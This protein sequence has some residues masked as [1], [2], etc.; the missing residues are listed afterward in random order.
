M[1]I[2]EKIFSPPKIPYLPF[3]KAQKKRN[4]QIYVWDASKWCRFSQLPAVKQ[5]PFMVHGKQI[6]GPC[7]G[8]KIIGQKNSKIHQ[9]NSSKKNHQKL[10]HRYTYLKKA[11]EST[12][13]TILGILGKLDV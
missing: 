13:K 3:T 5:V 12:R 1:L 2:I 6:F 9:K 10:H 8:S 7:N 11:Q 4:G